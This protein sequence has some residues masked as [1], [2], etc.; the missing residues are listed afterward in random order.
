[1]A[2]QECGRRVQSRLSNSNSNSNSGGGGGG[3]EGSLLLDATVDEIR[4]AIRG[5][6]FAGR[7]WV[8]HLVTFG[9]MWSHTHL[10]KRAVQSTE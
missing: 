8:T 2:V 4:C 6:L 5:E 7:A 1:M 10:D 9:H 3:G